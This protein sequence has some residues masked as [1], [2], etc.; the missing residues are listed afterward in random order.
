MNTF[1]LLAAVAVAFAASFGAGA[2]TY[3]SKPVTIIVPFPPGGSSDMIGRA[4]AQKMTQSLGQSV[5][6]ENKPGATGAIGATMVK[7]AHPDGYTLL[8]SSLAVFVV[9]PHLQKSL[10]YDPLKDFDLITVAVQAPNVLVCSPG[11]EA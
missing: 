5:I 6:V 7:N 2:Q 1:K 8:V 9:N 4:V 11:F 10:Q 3:P